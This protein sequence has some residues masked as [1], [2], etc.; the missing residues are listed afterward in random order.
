MHANF[1]NGKVVCDAQHKFKRCCE[2]FFLPDDMPIADPACK[3]PPDDLTL[4]QQIT[5][6]YYINKVIK[7]TFNNLILQYIM[8]YGDGHDNRDCC[9]KKGVPTDC[10]SWLVLNAN[11]QDFCHAD[12]Q[13]YEAKAGY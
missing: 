5:L 6:G 7:L 3:Y 12:G 10:V 8:C 1:S 11:C 4:G 13:S 9:A 2:Q